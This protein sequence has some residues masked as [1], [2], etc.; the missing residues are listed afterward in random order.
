MGRQN[1][2]R[3][4]RPG[5]TR[6]IRRLAVNVALAFQITGLII[7][8]VLGSLF[9]GIWVDRRLGSAPCITIVMM[10]VG[11][12]VALVGAYHLARSLSERK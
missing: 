5:E 3:P 11:F 6:N 7:C 10:V 12:V 4:G 8:S 2:N 9:L 1:A